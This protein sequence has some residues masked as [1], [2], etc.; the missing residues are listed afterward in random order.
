MKAKLN[1]VWIKYTLRLPDGCSAT[2]VRGQWKSEDRSLAKRCREGTAET[3]ESPKLRAILR[4]VS[5]T[6]RALGAVLFSEPLP[7]A[8]AEKRGTRQRVNKRAK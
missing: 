5:R 8:F 6:A 3:G 1:D 7:D 2:Y 4:A